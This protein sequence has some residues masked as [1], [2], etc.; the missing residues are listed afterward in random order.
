MGKT[1]IPVQNFAQIRSAALQDLHPRQT[2][3]HTQT[4]NIIYPTTAGEIT[5]YN[6]YKI[7]LDEMLHGLSVHN[8]ANQCYLFTVE[9]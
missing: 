4:A 6:M 1:S 9:N 2:D 5:T 3:R 8:S 7:Q